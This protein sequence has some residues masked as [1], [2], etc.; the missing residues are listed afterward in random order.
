M[1]YRLKSTR[2]RIIFMRDGAVRNWLM[3]QTIQ[4]VITFEDGGC[5]QMQDFAILANY[6]KIS[7]GSF[8]LRS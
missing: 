7:L 8:R 6:R 4:P 3:C 5:S 1:I 2:L